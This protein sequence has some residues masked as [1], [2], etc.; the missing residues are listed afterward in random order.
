M[1]KKLNIGFVALGVIPLVV[2]GCS[3]L[4]APYEPTSSGCIQQLEYAISVAMSEAESNEALI[5][6][7]AF[8]EKFEPTCHIN[9]NDNYG[10]YL[11]GKYTLETATSDEDLKKAASL[12]KQATKSRC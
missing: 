5:E 8:I 4:I 6:K 7:E 2:S 12:M 9:P 3:A 10:H 1:G 11:L